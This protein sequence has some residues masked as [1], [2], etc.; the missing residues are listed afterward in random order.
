MRKACLTIAYHNADYLLKGQIHESGI[1]IKFPARI[2]R[3]SDT[4]DSFMIRISL[5]MFLICKEYLAEKRSGTRRVLINRFKYCRMFVKKNF[6][7][8]LSENNWIL[9]SQIERF[10]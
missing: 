9:R 2:F 3:T 6:R 7:D 1:I 4:S 8:F 10:L 5:N